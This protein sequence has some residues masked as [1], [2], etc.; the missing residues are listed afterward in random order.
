MYTRLTF[1]H[2]CLYSISGI[3]FP[4]LGIAAAHPLQTAPIL[5]RCPGIAFP[6][7]LNLAAL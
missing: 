4:D 1:A 3:A 2:R 7:D 6:G 5:E